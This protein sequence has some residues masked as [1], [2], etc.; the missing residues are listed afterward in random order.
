[1][2]KTKKILSLMLSLLMIMTMMPMS[3]F[4]A[5]AAYSGTLE[6]GITWKLVN[7]YAY[8]YK[9]YINGTGEIPDYAWSEQPWFNESIEYVEVIIGEGI[10]HI[11]ESNFEGLYAKK[12]SLPSTLKS[13]GV[14]AFHSSSFESVE[15]PEGLEVIGERAFY[16]CTSLKSVEIPSTVTSIGKYAFFNCRKLDNV[17]FN[18]GLE[19]IGEDAFQETII[20]SFVFPSSVK[21]VGERAF[22]GDTP[23]DNVY[24]LNP[25]CE[26]NPN[27]FRCDSETV[28]YGYE[29]STAEA[30]AQ[31][32]N[33]T[34]CTIDQESCEHSDT[35]PIG[36][37]EPTCLVAGYEASLI[38][39]YCEKVMDGHEEIPPLGHDVTDWKILT[40]ATCG[41]EGSKIAEC[42]R[43]T[44]NGTVTVDSSEYPESDHDYNRGEDKTHIFSYDG[45]VKLIITFSDETETEKDYDFIYLY[46]GNGTEIG[47]Y[48]GT[49]LAGKTFEIEGDSFSV[50]LTSD[51]GAQ[52]YGFSFSSIVVDFI[53]ETAVEV[54]PATGEHNWENGV[55]AN[56][57]G[58]EHEHTDND[59][60]WITVVPAT[61]LPGKEKAYCSVCGKV[62]IKEILLDSA[63]YPESKHDY[64]SDSDEEWDFSYEGAAKLVLTFSDKTQTERNW[65]LIYLYDG[66]GTV[67][68][69]Y[70]DNDL[71]GKSVTVE[72]DKF[73][74]RLTSDGGVE[75]YGFKFDSITAIV[76]DENYIRE[77]PGNGN[78]VPV[79]GTY[80]D[81]ADGSHSYTCSVC[82]ETV[83]ADHVI[84]E[85]V[86]Q[87]CLGY[88]CKLC[89]ASFGEKNADVHAGTPGEAVPTKDGTQH[90]GIY[91]C[92]GAEAEA[93]DHSF[94]VNGKCFCGASC[95]HENFTDGV[96][97]VCGGN[98]ES[99]GH[100]YVDYECKACGEYQTFNIT[101]IADGE[102]VHTGEATAGYAYII[103]GYA[104]KEGYILV[105]WDTDG[106][107]EADCEASGYYGGS[108]ESDMTFV[109]VFA[110]SCTVSYYT[111][112]YDTGEYEDNNYGE[113]FAEGDT[114][115]LGYDYAYWYKFLGWATEPYGE[116]VYQPGDEY[117]VTDDVIFYS[118]AKPFE[119]TVDL[120]ADDAVWNDENGDPITVIS[121]TLTDFDVTLF[122]FPKRTGYKFVGFLDNNE[123]LYEVWTDEETGE[124][125]LDLYMNDDITVTAQWEECSDHIYGEYKVHLEPIC[126]ATGLEIAFCEYGCGAHDQRVIPALNHKDT[127]VTVEGKAATCT[128]PGYEEYELCTACGY[129]N[130][131]E[132]APLNHKDTLVWVPGVPATCTDDGYEGYQ[133]C[134]ACD[135]TTYVVSPAL[136]HDWSENDGICARENC[137]YEC[138]HEDQTGECCEI[139]GKSLHICDFSGGW[140]YD[141]DR[142]FK[143]CECGKISEESGHDWSA[144]DGQ[145]TVC[146]N[147]CMHEEE[148]GFN[149]KKC[150]A[151]RGSDGIPLTIDVSK[152][153]GS[154]VYLREEYTYDEDGYILVGSNP[155]CRV[156]VYHETDIEMENA[157]IG[158]L[159]VSE[160]YS[161]NVTL[162]GDNAIG[163]GGISFRESNLSV[164]GEDD[165]TLYI[166]SDAYGISTGGFAGTFI[167]NGGK[168]TVIGKSE[169]IQSSI[170]VKEVIVNDG[171][172]NAYS[173]N[174]FAIDGGNLIVNGGIVNAVS[175]ATSE[176]IFVIASAIEI[177]EG[178]LLTISAVNGNSIHNGRDNI[179]V[180]DGYAYVRYDTESDFVP[181]FNME[182]AIDRKSYVEVKVAPHS[183]SYTDGVCICG[184]ICY[185]SFEDSVCGICG[186]ECVNHYESGM[187]DG[188]CDR[189]D[190][191]VDILEIRSGETKE[192]TISSAHDDLWVKFVPLEDG[193]FT[194]SSS[195]ED[196]DPWVDVYAVDEYGDGQY[197]NYYADNNSDYDYNFTL[198]FEAKAGW[199]YWFILDRYYEMGDTFDITLKANRSITHQPTFDEPY[200]EFNIEEE[201]EYQWYTV[202]EEFNELKTEADGISGKF[203]ALD[204]PFPD[205][206]YSEEHGWLQTTKMENANLYF[207]FMVQLE[208]GEELKLSFADESGTFVLHPLTGSEILCTYSDGETVVKAKESGI[209]MLIN[210]APVA[211]R[212]EKVTSVLTPV[213][214][215]TAAEF[216]GEMNKSEIYLC[217]AFFADGDELVSDKVI[218]SYKITHQPTVDEP[219]VATNDENASYQWY[220][221]TGTDEITDDA[222]TPF[223]PA[224]FGISSSDF[225]ST[226]SY[227]DGEG[228]T[229]A[230]MNSGIEG[231]YPLYYCVIELE[232]GTK[233]DVEFS[234]DV[235]HAILMDTD[236]YE[237]SYMD[238]MGD[239]AT[240]TVE[241][242][243]SYLLMAMADK[244]LT[245]KVTSDGF[246][247]EYEAIEGETSA[248]IENFEP[249][250]TYAC[251]VTFSDD[252]KKMSD[253]VKNSYRITHQ[254]TVDEPFVATNDENATYQWYEVIGGAEITDKNASAV[255]YS[256]GES[257]YDK[258]K[259]WTGVPFEEDY[260]GQEFFT[261]ELKA[262]E[263][264][265]VE[266]TGDFYDFIGV[267]DY[268]LSDDV[269]TYVEEGVTTY[270]F[271]P[272][273][274]GNY[275][276]YTYGGEVTVKAYIGEKSSY[277]A[278]EDETSAKLDGFM[279]GKR[280]VCEVT[281]AD[282]SEV[283]SDEIFEEFVIT[284][285]PTVEEPYVATNDE[286]ATYQWFEYVRSVVE[287]TDENA[288][289]VSYLWGESS[290]DKETGW[291]GIAYSE[292][293]DYIE[294][295]KAELKKGDKIIIE[296]DP[297]EIR[298]IGMYDTDT[299]LGDWSLSSSDVETYELVAQEDGTYLVYAYRTSR[300][301][302]P[303]L[304]ASVECG[305][306]KEID[307][308]DSAE[309]KEFSLNKTYVCKVTSADGAELMSDAF[310]EDA[311][312]THQPTVDEPY[313]ETNDPEAIYQWYEVSGETVEITD[314]NADIV[315]DEFSSSAY[316][317]ETG[318]KGVY[319]E[320]Y[321][322]REFFTVHLKAGE[323]ITVKLMGEFRSYGVGIWDLELDDGVWKEIVDGVTVYE[324]TAPYEA[325]YTLQAYVRDDNDSIRAYFGGIAEYTA[326]EGET[327]AELSALEI[328][329]SYA[330]EV[331]YFNGIKEMSDRVDN[332]YR[333]TH[334]PTIAAPYVETNDENA[335]YQ[336]YEFIDNSYELDDSKADTFDGVEFGAPQDFIDELEGES[337]YS[338]GEGWSGLYYSMLDYYVLY[339]MTFDIKEGDILR[340]EFSSDMNEVLVADLASNN[341]YELSHNGNKAVYKANKD[342][343]LTLMGQAD[344]LATVKAFIVDE[345][346]VAIDGETSAELKDCT[347]G[348]TYACEVTFTD[349]SK[350]MSDFFTAASH[351]HTAGE[352]VVE[353]EV[354]ADCENQG[355]YDEVAY[356]TVCGE[357]L[358]RN[359]VTVDALGHSYSELDGKC[360]CGDALVGWNELDG[361]WYY[362]FENNTRAEGIT[363]V[364]YPT[365]EIDGIEYAADKE[366]L[367]YC[368]KKGLTFIDAE[369]GLFF[370][371][372][373]GK[374]LN[375]YTGITEYMD[376]ARYIENGFMKWHPGFV[377]AEGELYYFIG[378]E[379]VGG[380]TPANGD[381]YIIKING[382][383]GFVQNAVYNFVNGKLSGADGIVDGKYYED[384][385][386]MMGNGL[387]AV[388]IDGETKYIYVRSSGQVVTDAQYWVGPNDYK[389][390]PGIY[391]FD[392]DGYML[393]IKTE[394][395]TGIVYENGGYYF[396]ENGVLA[397]KGLIKY[398]GTANNGTV[399]ENDWI[400]VRSNGQL[401]ANRTYWTTKNV[402]GELKSQNYN[403]DECGRMINKNGIIE[404]NGNLYYYVNGNKQ[405]CLGLIEIDGKLYYVRTAGE[406]VRNREYWITNVNDTGVVARNYYFD[407]NGV[408]QNPIYNKTEDTNGI[409]DGYYYIDGEIAY[410]AGVVELTD[411]AGET[412]YIYV[413][414]NGKLATGNYWPTNTNGLLENRGYDWGVDG[415]YYP[416]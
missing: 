391:S 2:Q 189:C 169:F 285:Q 242:D 211:V 221:V 385:K 152:A 395:M 266:L 232:K 183:H 76:Y 163:E 257:S 259:G 161:V 194:L 174:A 401:A 234:S 107:G 282:G 311:A 276:F 294:Y 129:N 42:S 139:C 120:G 249:G 44:T 360:V 11:G 56:G 16:T 127:L 245:A 399:Y 409:V 213:E 96:C 329:K 331:T 307:G 132:I 253:T 39:Y 291:T 226:A 98:C 333:I 336:W 68:G 392:K 149:C 303:T 196:V 361:N 93:E 115:Y 80:E 5:S 111:F 81:K 106:D 244:K 215:E 33:I 302:N 224:S 51:Y 356:C 293:D 187:P 413:R 8:K 233:I 389:I 263:T 32:K 145:C 358:D 214:G 256:W 343:R 88:Q 175:E 277:E 310:G 82:N 55:C 328:G 237:P 400:Y 342:M 180:G 92:C 202:E 305:G 118:V 38:C 271:T 138:L 97:D 178:A 254:P 117:T 78:H 99:L 274:D 147:T 349:G 340:C 261:V 94:E 116:A 109:A 9:L 46:D 313:V 223:N 362:F 377:E 123:Y 229:P 3:V 36:R 190:K 151:E 376:A 367:D 191:S 186:Y 182:Q 50:R 262:G 112:N 126:N 35:T 7:E 171:E 267:Y 279:I 47:K 100:T 34:F 18:H 162:D 350:E 364:A 26:I 77:I 1:M 195:G 235:L 321:G 405:Q 236:G 374:F 201:A 398:T 359:T 58:A 24:V 192:I 270:E 133:Y 207:T 238:C 184:E 45:A 69:K 357:E 314:K 124:R 312:I 158:E 177:S 200:L 164:Y 239:K 102:V 188:Y 396:Y 280:F 137:G 292:S 52:D 231:L 335:E 287:L 148:T 410:G 368:E 65:D 75:K 403:F 22:Y 4:Q 353:N 402:T 23:A 309:L 179:V 243:S 384:S 366:T 49:E 334:Q 71:A 217:K 380:N 286:N 301:M 203:S 125:G 64:D 316:Y 74:I 341:I 346:Y 354:A 198:E 300:E 281:F 288:D 386:L 330:C 352:A 136:K 197:T 41:A 168:I 252:S 167:V 143:M 411:E 337:S 61:C 295:L 325:D 210:T 206:E 381:T 153:W 227:I 208:K 228:W 225:S 278:I 10:T 251:E 414:S 275:T 248:A 89:G 371:D 327:S 67:I 332:F 284:H 87:T 388:E 193:S 375:T 323:K 348:K 255:S 84:D 140:E 351:S 290:Y 121:C 230:V 134:T 128:E 204:L 156:L 63:T 212:A 308:E 17:K 104:E 397:Y 264:I 90:A 108:I 412:F 393:G 219:Y 62:F 110:K 185:H 29:G 105:G 54:I 86:E 155:D 345:S 222:A 317:E 304:K 113:T 181:V 324:F 91:D 407:N 247:A 176:S 306:Y 19:I 170:Y 72:G 59:L 297:A 15:L 372:E 379:A 14:D 159:S 387:T 289:K 416:A 160:G 6:N 355:S 315:Y 326:I 347:L 135:Y 114:V 318:W 240:Y 365:E 218:F 298:E 320:D 57:C 172:L 85:T 209:Y 43:C 199:T 146:Q 157:Q 273:R 338:E 173:E 322:G 30:Y 130:L 37:K 394:D 40:E 241:K 141:V 319:F 70:S 48:S 27:V 165:D 246:V 369:T 296:L 95:T 260:D 66:N 101:Y 154:F 220:K 404:E 339:Y 363:R 131:V 53:D 258:E 28:I 103:D 205:V 83:A 269:Y 415:R 268:D 272:E 166:E 150:G 390:I 408:M 383:K 25:E 373:D 60:E 142:H 119:A 79:E 378:D 299:D 12:V 21:T 13:I 283:M 382:F 144:K 122:N 265:V 73:T 216:K 344:E 406:L 31:N 370:F 250:S 20:T